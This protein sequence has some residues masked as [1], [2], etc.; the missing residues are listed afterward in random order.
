[1]PG[2]MYNYPA[3]QV[4]AAPWR[5]FARMRRLRRD[6][7]Q[8]GGTV[9][10]D[11]DT[12]EVLG[13]EP[14]SFGAQM[15]QQPFLGE[16][17]GADD[18][19]D[20]DDPEDEYALGA[21]DDAIGEADQVLGEASLYGDELGADEVLGRSGGNL[22]RS[23]SQLN[24]QIAKA[25]RQAENIRGPFA[26]KRLATKKRRIERMQA[27]KRDLLAKKRDI[28]QAR[29]RTIRAAA[30]IATGAA[31]AVA[32]QALLQAG[33][34]G[35]QVLNSRDMLTNRVPQGIDAA[36]LARM[37]QGQA[38]AGQRY[39][40]AAPPGSGRINPVQLYADV[41]TTNPRNSLTVPGGGITTG[42]TLRTNSLPFATNKLIGFQA[43]VY[44][45]DS[46]NGCIGL[47]RNLK[48][49]GSPNLFLEDGWIQ[50]AQY[51]ASKESMGG[52]RAY[53]VLQNTNYASVEIGAA[54]DAADVLTI[55]CAILVDIVTD[56]TF[57]AGMPGPYA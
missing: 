1:M 4:G 20:F 37:R 51:D 9:T 8:D 27:K 44:G 13:Y 35:P 19:D 50:A 48:V 16:D 31:G 57:G 32:T 56:D 22:D 26:K 43:S 6:Q 2:P 36:L 34:G 11:A 25:Q 46:T 39:N 21:A 29:R 38:A 3:P 17:L 24:K 5:P 52:L 55:A 40:V 18:D 7:A 33:I 53:P 49:Q 47:L 42:T 30:G 10:S 45:T 28:E 12:G 15:V 14:P 54:G 23:I 41:S